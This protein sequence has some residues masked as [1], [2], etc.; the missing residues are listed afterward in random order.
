[1]L[2]QDIARTDALVSASEHQLE[3]FPR[4]TKDEDEDGDDGDRHLQLEHLSHLLGAAKESARAAVYL[5]AQFAAEL[6]KR[7]AGS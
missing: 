5:S 3:R 7:G 2:R 4:N 6:A 1:M